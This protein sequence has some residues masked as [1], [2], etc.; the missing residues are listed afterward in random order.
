MKLNKNQRYALAIWLGSKVKGLFNDHSVVS[1][2]DEFCDGNIREW[3]IIYPFGFAGKI[4]NVE[5]E[6][7]I[8]GYSHGELSKKAYEEQQETIKSW[9]LEVMSMLALFA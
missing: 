9:N 2:F 5:C 8:T 4:W 1:N 3:R 7:Y 6:I